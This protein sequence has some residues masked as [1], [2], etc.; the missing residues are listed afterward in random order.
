VSQLGESFS[1][2]INSSRCRHLSPTKRDLTYSSSKTEFFSDF[3]N[4]S[5][6]RVHEFRLFLPNFEGFRNRPSLPELAKNLRTAES[7]ILFSLSFQLF[8]DAMT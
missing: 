8:G 5:G 4:T 7:Q 6:G 3:Y 2:S 1:A